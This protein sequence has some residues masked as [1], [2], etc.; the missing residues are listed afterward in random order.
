M[1][2]NRLI[3]LLLCLC[4]VFALFTGFAESASAAD[5]YVAY[6]IKNG[7]NLY[8]LVGK[9]GMNYGTVKYVIMALNGFTNE[10][11]LSQL[12][13]GQTILLPT[14]NQAAASLASKALNSNAA[15]ATT[16]VVTTAGG[17]T[18][19]TAATTTTTSTSSAS[20][21]N[22]YTPAYYLVYHEVKKGETLTSICKALGVNYYDYATVVLR[23]N[24]L[25]SADSL[26]VGQYVWVPAK[27]GT[28]GGTIA[29]IAYSVKR[30]DNISS[31]CAQYNTNYSEYKAAVKA[32][33]PKIA[34]VEKLN[35]GQT[36]YIPVYTSYN[37]AVA[38]NSSTAAGTEGAPSITQ[39]T[40]YAI[41]FSVPDSKK[42]GDPFVIVGTQANV[43]RAQAGSTVIIR[44]NAYSGYAVTG[45]KV[46]R[47][48][49]N[50]QVA[51][52]DY[53]FTMPNSNVQITVDY[54]A[55]KQIRK[56][57]SPHGSFDTMVAGSAADTAF[58]GDRVVI[59]AYPDDRYEVK[60]VEVYD[61]TSTS[62]TPILTAEKDKNTNKYYFTMPNQ[63]VRVKVTFDISKMVKLYY[64]TPDSLDYS[65]SMNRRGEVR[66]FINGQQV[67]EANPGDTVTAVV[68]P[69]DGW[70]ITSEP[71][72]DGDVDPSTPPKM[73]AKKNAE[74]TYTFK[75]ASTP[76]K[77]RVTVIVEFVERIPYYLLSVNLTGN[78]NPGL[79]SFTVTDGITG[80]VRKMA[81]YAYPGDTVEIVPYTTSGARW[82]VNYSAGT[83][84]PE[85]FDYEYNPEETAN[86]TTI[87]ITGAV[88]NNWIDRG[89]KFKMPAAG[90][91]VEA[92]FDA[93]AYGS[94]SVY[95]SDTTFY[96][97]RKY[98][99]TG[100]QTEYGAVEIY[101]GDPRTTGKPVGTA[102]PGTELW[103]K[104]T[105]NTNYRVRRDYEGTTIWQYYIY[106]A[107]ASVYGGA[108]QLAVSDIITETASSIIYAKFKMPQNDSQ[109]IVYYEQFY[110]NS[111][112]SVGYDTVTI[113]AVNMDKATGETTWTQK[114]SASTSG[115]KYLSD[116]VGQ[117]PV[118]M[119]INSVHVPDGSKAVAGNAVILY[120]ELRD[121]RRL[122]KAI[123]SRK[124][125]TWRELLPT[126]DGFFWYQIDETDIDAAKDPLTFEIWTT[127]KEKTEYTI[128]HGGVFDASHLIN[129]TAE[130]ASAPTYEVYVDGSLA[131]DTMGQCKVA[132]GSTV[133]IEI[134]SLISEGYSLDQVNINGINFT[135]GNL[136]WDSPVWYYE[137]IMPANNVTT[138]VLYKEAQNEMGEMTN[139]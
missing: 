119:W 93:P 88:M 77:N 69:A 124:D 114:T 17:T 110:Q 56:L 9:M 126:G 32:I 8:T 51:V 74:Y 60:S 10:A 129:L 139:P 86:H 121:N 95:N 107:D 82:N 115:L 122:E 34:N 127:E 112:S 66:F 80:T 44:P 42:F 4:M 136:I 16:A 96:A 97:N 28:A 104:I 137:F 111:P 1:K 87:A 6:T 67:T 73:Q 5:D 123:V 47:T 12:Q 15:T 22:G 58:Y 72:F 85:L 89:Y 21:Y 105:P 54:A 45:V 26:K 109:V 78:G 71:V 130:L 25:A 39:A 108:R 92:R 102:S 75:V 83:A 134:P 31:I 131:I 57:N 99:V 35:I 101:D 30:D 133:R 63:H 84:T 55:G 94:S 2:T 27:T 36:V 11:Q 76:S 59:E 7:D 138:E 13:P 37:N 90:V 132:E 53:A 106:Y 38:G 117:M 91:N 41:G 20:T 64:N 50:A 100:S 62:S 43:T 61:A 65:G 49:S 125:G 23:L 46:V 118:Q 18:T 3:S 19:G 48:D 79:I 135:M 29:V 98:I 33:N 116:S 128:S 24:N 113:K 14:S 70:F 52:N 40:G 103:M 68:I 120:F 81:E